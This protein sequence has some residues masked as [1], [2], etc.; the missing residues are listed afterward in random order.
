M[1]HT[2]ID[3]ES[4]TATD[5]DG[6]SFTLGVATV[7][8]YLYA[9]KEGNGVVTVRLASE[10]LRA[11]A[12]FCARAVGAEPPLVWRECDPRDV[13]VG[14]L[15][16]SRSDSC[17]LR[18]VV[19][20]LAHGQILGGDASSRCL[21]WSPSVVDW[22][23]WTTAPAPEYT[24]EERALRDLLS[25]LDPEKLAKVITAAKAAFGGGSK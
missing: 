8:T 24:P 19:T 20:E 16:E 15:V 9:G 18:A 3:G 2:V 22:A 25:D 1:S 11:L 4:I 12:E 10:D 13:K 14:W 17:T 23:L 5:A 6:D 7:S 21:L